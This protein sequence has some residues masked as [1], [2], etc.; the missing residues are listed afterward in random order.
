MRVE[1]FGKDLALL[2][3]WEKILL[4]RSPFIVDEIYDNGEAKILVADFDTARKEVL[5]YLKRYKRESSAYMVLL[6]SAPDI[7]LGERLLSLN[8]KGYGNSYM[9]AVHLQSCIE[10]V[11]NG[12]I[13]VFPEFVYALIGKLSINSS[14]A[15]HSSNS[16]AGALTTREREIVSY[17]FKG[18]NNAEIADAM[19]ITVRTVKAHLGNIYE[20]AGVSGRLELVLLLKEEQGS[21]I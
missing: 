2:N 11:A 16:V 21:I 17:L 1:L 10:T 18:K 8:V 9:Q 3:R 15:P 12:N 7:K 14:S 19:R 20:K 6:Q 13:W 5:E 4:D